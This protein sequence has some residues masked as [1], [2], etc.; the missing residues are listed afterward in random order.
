MQDGFKRNNIHAFKLSKICYIMI[1]QIIIQKQ[2][3]NLKS[4]GFKNFKIIKKNIS[5]L[6]LKMKLFD[7]VWCYE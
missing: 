5:N 6:P 1:F 4:L 7:V 3:K 2:Q